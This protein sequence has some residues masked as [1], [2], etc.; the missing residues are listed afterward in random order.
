MKLNHKNIQV[1]DIALSNKNS[2]SSLM[3][4]LVNGKEVHTE[5]KLT[6]NPGQF[7]E[8]KVQC[9]TL[10]SLNFSDVDFVKIDVEGHELEVIQG[11]RKVL[12]KYKPILLVEIEQRHLEHSFF[13]VVK[14][15]ENLGYNT[16]F[17]KNYN[18]QTIDKFDLETDQ[19]K[20]IENVDSRDYL[21]NFL[22]F[23]IN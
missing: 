15:I 22:F 6:N 1:H 8:K 14:Y 20:N 12:K 19:I 16:Y 18:L 5:A 23:P 11:S 4:P 17:F 9:K 21:N 7:I 13:D 2:V 10:D 3:I